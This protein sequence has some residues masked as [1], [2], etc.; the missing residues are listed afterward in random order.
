[1]NDVNLRANRFILT[2]APHSGKVDYVNDVPLTLA[3][4]TEKT[5]EVPK[6]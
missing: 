4:E 1:M 6:I 3:H 5:L 2:Y